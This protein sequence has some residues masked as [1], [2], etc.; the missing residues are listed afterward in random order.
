[1]SIIILVWKWHIS[2]YLTYLTDFSSL[3]PHSYNHWFDGMALLHQFRIEDG[4][5]TY[6][7]RFLRSDSYKKN[8]ERDRIMVS[9]FGTVAMPDPCKNIFLRFLARFEMISEWWLWICSNRL[10]SVMPCWSCCM[11]HAALLLTVH[12]Q[13][14]LFYNLLSMICAGYEHVSY[15]HP[16]TL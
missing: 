11:A 6:K 14:Q 7:N 5:V 10:F 13:V 12:M 2:F 3:F 16:I 8:T 1:M 9:E 15:W 4:Q